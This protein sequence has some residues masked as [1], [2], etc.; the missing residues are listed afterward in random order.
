[1]RDE[2]CVDFL[3]WCLPQMGLRW[4]GFRK[5]R[6]TVCKRIGHRIR[7]LAL[8]DIAAYRGYLDQHSQEWKR[9][10]EYC[11]IPISRFWRDR[12]LFDWLAGTALPAFAAEAMK[13]R[14]R[15][16]RCWC[17]G[18]A[19]GEEPYSLRIAWT[20]RAEP[21]EPLIRIVII[22]TDVDE[23]M[24]A[25]A[26]AGRYSH[27]S[28]RDLP[29]EWLARAFERD[30][31]EYVLRAEMRD[32]VEIIRQDL[33]RNWPDGPFDII[34]CRN[35]AFTYFDREN[36]RKMLDRLAERLRENGLLIIGDH[37]KLPEGGPAFEQAADSLPVYR[38]IEPHRRR[39]SSAAA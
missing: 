17:A 26:R 6:R 11:R 20:A 38:R 23:T 19:S 29:K 36:Q 13:R 14:E 34:F 25:R 28:L 3:Q 5:V 1:M 2:E 35:T 39:G 33:L 30:G 24:I 37:E 18:C 31:D 12:A 16:V 7:E 9:L 4:A 10:E 32:G 21:T 8:S 27:G 22:A 15:I